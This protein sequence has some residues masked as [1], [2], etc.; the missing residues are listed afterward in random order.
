MFKLHC[1]FPADVVA[2]DAVPAAIGA[3]GVVEAGAHKE[4]IA[5]NS[6]HIWQEN[7]KGTSPKKTDI[8]RK[9]SLLLRV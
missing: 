3:G 5:K 9:S 2:A 4:L 6:E 1:F 7:K 8:N